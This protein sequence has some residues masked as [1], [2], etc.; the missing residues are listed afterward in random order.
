MSR[1]NG[2]PEALAY[3]RPA[4]EESALSLDRTCI[5]HIFCGRIESAEGY[6]L[7]DP[8][9]MIN[10]SMSDSATAGRQYLTDMTFCQAYAWENRPAALDRL[11]QLSG[12]EMCGIC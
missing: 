6:D 11:D 3:L 7:N 9:S 2:R 1:C 10:H 12:V 4:S 8:A 5:R